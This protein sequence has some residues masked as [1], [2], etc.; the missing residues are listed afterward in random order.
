MSQRFDVALPE[1]FPARYNI[2]PSQPVLVVIGGSEDRPEAWQA[3]GRRCW[4]AGASF[5]PGRATLPPCRFCS[6][7][8]RKRPPFGMPSGRH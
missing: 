2:A 4:R 6:T 5:L 7:R 3:A 8:A 1:E